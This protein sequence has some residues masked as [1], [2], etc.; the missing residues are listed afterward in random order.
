MKRKAVQRKLYNI[1]HMYA[2]T[3]ADEMPNA[4]RPSDDPDG[5]EGFASSVLPPPDLPDDQAKRSMTLLR[6]YLA[7][8][9]ELYSYLSY[10]TTDDHG[11]QTREFLQ[12]LSVASTSIYLDAVGSKARAQN[13]GLLMISAQPLEVML[14]ESVTEAL[15]QDP[16]P[17]EVRVFSLRTPDKLDL[18]RKQGGPQLPVRSCTLGHQTR[19]VATGVF[20]CFRQ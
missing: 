18:I 10:P 11:N 12:V 1:Q 9:L 14:D 8:A 7:D 17:E 5:G 2:F 16:L 4:K 3:S 15:P 20:V 19:A 6:D 13:Q